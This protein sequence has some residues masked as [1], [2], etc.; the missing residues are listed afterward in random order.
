MIS[1]DSIALQLYTVRDA[2]EADFNG[3]IQRVAE[4]GYRAV[5]TASF[6]NTTPQAA[7]TLFDSLD[8]RVS[9]A[10]SKLPLGDNRA[11]ILET[12]DA[13]GSP[14]LVCPMLDPSFMLPSLIV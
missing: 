3:T 2:L 4:M 9:S 1:Q 13:L 14:Y 12:I 7:R 8:I 10:H 6:P 5:E 11:E